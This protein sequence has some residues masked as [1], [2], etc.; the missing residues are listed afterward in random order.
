MKKFE[1]KG[2]R[3]EPWDDYEEDNIKRFHHVITPDGRTTSIGLS[4]YVKLDEDTF[5]KWIDLGMP[6]RSNTPLLKEDIHRMW[7]QNSKRF[8]TDYEN[9]EVIDALDRINEGAKD[10]GTLK[11]ILDLNDQE[12]IWYNEAYD[13]WRIVLGK[14]TLSKGA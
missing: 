12:I 10:P 9:Q 11:I 4:P 6:K 13:S 14:N 2:Y 3:Y 8:I 7:R 1:Y 5:Q